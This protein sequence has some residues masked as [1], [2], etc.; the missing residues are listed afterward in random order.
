MMAD[1]AADVNIFVYTG[2]RV[3]Q[4]LRE[5]ITH[6]RIDESVTTIEEGAFADCFSL[7]YVDFH[8]G[9][10]IVELCAF[11]MC[12]SLRRINLPGVRIIEDHAFEDCRDL[13]VAEFGNKLETI[14]TSAFGHCTSLRHVK[15]PSIRAIGEYAFYLCIILTDAEFGTGLESIGNM[16]FD[17][18]FSLQRIAIPL[19]AY[20]FTFDNDEERYTQFDGCDELV[21]VDIVGEIR[22]TISHLSLQR[23]RNE[24]NQEIN[25]INQ[26]LPTT[27][28]FDKVRMIDEWIQ[29]ILRRMEHY[30]AEH[31][32]LLKEAT[33]LLELALWKA[34]LRQD[35]EKDSFDFDTTK[36]K[37]ARIDVGNARQ[38]ARVT[39]GA[40]IIVKD[41]LPFL[42]L[43]ST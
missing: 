23:W 36:P 17:K 24:M 18:C 21:T 30:K 3:P 33:T 29:S 28:A 11:Y 7:L 9:V 25:R 41:V 35:E 37:I 2:G 40:D 31:H 32:N 20:M 43:P 5:I 19:N 13:E 38:E 10:D 15:I 39:C 4:H 16:A 14:G 8:S 26:F 34:K 12:Y 1:H 42:K 22:K 6:A 27:R